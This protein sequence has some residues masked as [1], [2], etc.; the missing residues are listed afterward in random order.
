[1]DLIVEGNLVLFKI[2]KRVFDK[3]VKQQGSDND[4]KRTELN[5]K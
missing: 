1:M 2:A 4:G 3:Y 5:T